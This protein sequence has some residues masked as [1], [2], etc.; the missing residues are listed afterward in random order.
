MAD[1]NIIMAGLTHFLH[2]I[3]KSRE[4]EYEN[5]QT[6][7]FTLSVSQH[8]KKTVIVTVTFSTY[9]YIPCKVVN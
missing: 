6:I 3:D 9:L 4:Q 8:Y 5:K 2:Y 1:M 7:L